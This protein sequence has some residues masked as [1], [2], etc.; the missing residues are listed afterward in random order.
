MASCHGGGPQAPRSP[1]GNCAP[2][3][4]S[5]GY[6][7]PS[8]MKLAPL[9]LCAAIQI[10]GCAIPSIEKL[11]SPAAVR[12]MGSPPDEEQAR[13]FMANFI[14]EKTGLDPAVDITFEPLHRGWY[15]PERD[16][17]FEKAADINGWVYAWQID[18][19]IAGKDM[20]RL[21]SNPHPWHFWFRN[22]NNLVAYSWRDTEVRNWGPQNTTYLPEPLGFTATR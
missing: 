14:R 3:I 2:R 5:T 18:T 8:K 22:G 9:A 16:G 15:R 20:P 7:T 4:L 12:E 6:A 21:N 10:T 17:L 19:V 1:S 11:N 13:V